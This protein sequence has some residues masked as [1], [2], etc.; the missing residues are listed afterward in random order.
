MHCYI[1]KGDAKRGVDTSNIVKTKDYYKPVEI[2]KNGNYKMKSGMVYTCFSTDF[3]IPEADSWRNE[4]WQMMRQRSDCTF[5]F[6]TKRIDRFM[7]CIPGDW[8]NGYDNVVIGCT[9]ENQ[10][11]AD[12][13]LKISANCP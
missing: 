3:L 13:K 12:Y 8:G 10:K 9:V 2:L 11:N 5:L 4:C 7:Q 1:H 6:L